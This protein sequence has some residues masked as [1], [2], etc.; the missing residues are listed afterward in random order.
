MIFIPRL[1]PYL[2]EPVLILYNRESYN[3]FRMPSRV[4]AAKGTLQ[5]SLSDRVSCR[6]ALMSAEAFKKWTKVKCGSSGCPPNS[7]V[8]LISGHISGG[9]EGVDDGE[10]SSK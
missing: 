5:V 3:N 4:C 1:N 8:E 7:M 9:D 10:G 6:N 2:C